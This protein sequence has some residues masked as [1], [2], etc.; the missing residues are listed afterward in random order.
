MEAAMK[1]S[2][3]AVILGLALVMM[4]STGG[5]A[6]DL[7]LDPQTLW[8]AVSEDA[9]RWPAV[10]G[11]GDHIVVVFVK[12]DRS[13]IENIFASVIPEGSTTPLYYAISKHDTDCAHPSIA[14]HASSGL[15]LVV[16]T[17]NQTDVFLRTFS[18]TTETVGTLELI[19]SGDTTRGYPAIAC[20]QTAGSCLVAFNHDH[21]RIKG[22]YV[23]VDPSGIYQISP[24]YDLSDATTA[25]RPHLAWGNG[26]STYLVAYSEQHSTGGIL[27][28][29]THVIDHDDPLVDIKYFHPSTLAVPPGFSPS[30]YDTLVRDAAF[31]PC[32]QKFLISIDYDAAGDGSNFDVWAAVVHPTDPINFTPMAIADTPV[33]EYSSA[34]SFV[35]GD[36]ESTACGSM[37]RLLVGYINNEVGLMAVELRGNS[38]PLNPVYTYVTANQHLHV[39][40][41]TPMDRVN[42]VR[43]LGGAGERR[44]LMVYQIH[45]PFSG[46]DDIWGK[47]VGL[48]DQVYLPLVLR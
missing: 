12:A 47:F 22:A 34:I 40:Y 20:N 7:A 43:I 26:V 24:V 6:Q 1:V 29:Y 14:Y 4:L 32:T 33:S 19:A 27:P 3:V 39:E 45:H 31:D 17:C 5:L 21:S 9:E 28:S 48:L 2:K 38:N 37:D 23:D 15:F 36:T 25:G 11:G 10:A 13:G 18:P 8:I 46:D 30:G 35:S 42:A 44:F 16:Y 41:H